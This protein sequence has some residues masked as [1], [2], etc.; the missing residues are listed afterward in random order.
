MSK[1]N[2]VVVREKP[3]CHGLGRTDGAG[4]A[5]VAFRHALHHVSQM[6]VVEVPERGQL[7]PGTILMVLREDPVVLDVRWKLQAGALL[8]A[9]KSLVTNSL[10]R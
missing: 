8:G 7:I 4:D 10:T 3:Q 5:S 1:V 6:V 2:D 9:N